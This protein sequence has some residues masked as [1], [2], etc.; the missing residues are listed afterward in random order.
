VFKLWK[1]HGGIDEWVGSRSYKA[2]C[3]VYGKLLAMAVQHWTIVTGCWAQVDRSPTKAARVVR[4]LALSLALAISRLERLLWVLA[5]AGELMA[6]ACR[7]EH[8]KGSP[9]AHDRILCFGAGP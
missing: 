1:S 9:T 7:M 8:H 6:V 2:L 5:H 4:A 3:A